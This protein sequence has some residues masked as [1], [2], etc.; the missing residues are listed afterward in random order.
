[1]STADGFTSIFV[2]AGRIVLRWLRRLVELPSM[3]RI[4]VKEGFEGEQAR[5]FV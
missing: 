1:M 4:R 2:A 3:R 5:N